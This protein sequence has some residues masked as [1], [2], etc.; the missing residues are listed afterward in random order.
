LGFIYS[1]N[2]IPE[3]IVK[4][5]LENKKAKKG[6]EI[7][8]HQGEIR[9]RIGQ[10]LGHK[11]S[12]RQ[13][14]KNLSSMRDQKL[15][16]E[17]DLK[18]GK[19]GYKVYYSLTDKAETMYTLKILGS[20]EIVERRKNLYQLLIFFRAFKRSS[21]ITERQLHSF[22]RR[23]GMTKDSL[24]IVKNSRTPFSASSGIIKDI[25]HFRPLKGVQ[26]T[27]WDQGVP[28]KD[29]KGAIYHVTIPGFSVEEFVAHLNKLRKGKEPQPYLGITDVPSVLSI[30]YSE[31]E[32]VDAVESFRS[33]G[34]I[35]PINEVFPGETRYDLADES[36]IKFIKDVW[37]VHEYDLRLLFERLVYGGR[38]KEE[39]INYLILMYGKK[40]A[41]RILAN[42]YHARKEYKNCKNQEEEK[43][44]KKFIRSFETH[45]RSLIDDIKKR[46]KN[47]IDSYEILS[48]LIEGISFSHF[49]SK[50]V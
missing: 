27:K 42:A 32:I 48:Q 23:M 19:R 11:I 7:R 10:I 13:V 35:K 5:L 34:I 16:N 43:I 1:H 37:L 14:R 22:L 3:A 50:P 40:I 18:E 49:V 31:S 2:N 21:S 28:N 12:Y 29:P 24:E 38:P 41:D 30:K 45:R 44:A 36:L 17:Y 9:R 47:V 20:N 25:I 33:N 26:I 4:V 6:G 46:H 8:L 15:L 39:D